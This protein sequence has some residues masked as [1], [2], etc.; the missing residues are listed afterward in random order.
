[1]AN[2]AILVARQE[3]EVDFGHGLFK[4][5]IVEEPIEG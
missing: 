5:Y 2:T 1:M 4:R 3:V